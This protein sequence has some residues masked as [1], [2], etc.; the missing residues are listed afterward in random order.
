LGKLT[1][2]WGR[3]G[4]HCRRRERACRS[5][6]LALAVLACGAVACQQ[7]GDE[8]APAG[9]GAATRGGDAT[10]GPLV[11]YSGVDRRVVEPLLE[12][13]HDASGTEVEVRYG[14]PEIL[15]TLLEEGTR[16]RAD[17]VYAPDA[18]TLGAL[19]RRGL[20]LELPMEAMQAVPARFAAVD[21]QRDWL[22]ISG[23]ARVIAHGAGVPA[24]GLPRSLEQLADRRHRA[25]FGL[26]PASPSLQAQ[27]SAYRIAESEEAL[28]SLLA[29]IRD[30]APQLF[31]DEGAVV[32]AV[33]SGEVTFG[34]V[35]HAEVWRQLGG[36]PAGRVGLFALDQG[37]TAGFVNLS[38]VGVLS[39]D[40][41]AV[42]L[43]RFLLAREA[44]GA[45][46]AATF[47]YAVAVDM[48]PPDGVPPLAPGS[49]RRVDFADVAA[50]LD[51]TRTALRRVGL[52]R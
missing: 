46:A 38:A 28:D 23:R 52:L 21:S 11:L 19:S 31:P 18:A 13:F 43:V 37:T 35:D 3:V 48:P 9:G 34:L 24:A 32:R 22:G 36:D 8:Q 16:T 29:G 5:A 1:T 47:E 26:A 7:A 20:L 39:Q 40:P 49:A 51:E 6:L 27:L 10:D 42:D 25:A 45:L 4:D 50:V 44:Q 33:A 41:R 2:S 15:A 14:G 12:A 17:V 30:N